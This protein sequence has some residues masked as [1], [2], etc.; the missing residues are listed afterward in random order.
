FRA[1][2]EDN[3]LR[4]VDI[5]FPELG[6]AMR[7][8]GKRADRIF[9]TTDLSNVMRKAHGDGW[10]LLGDAACHLDQCTAIGIT[11]A[12][13]DAALAGQWVGKALSNELPMDE[14]LASYSKIRDT[15]MKTQF[16]YVSRVSECRIPSAEQMGFY[17]AL[18]D[19]EA[20]LSRFLGFGASIVPRDDYF[21]DDEI[22]NLSKKG[23]SMTHAEN[24]WNSM[25]MELEQNPWAA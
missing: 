15:E 10:L 1:D 5:C 21:N 16:D 2:M 14:A 12:F 17:A 13:R 8:T 9:G 25:C 19:D 6:T 11:H 23:L 20:A 3:I 7:E 24:A 22:R 4:T 18:S